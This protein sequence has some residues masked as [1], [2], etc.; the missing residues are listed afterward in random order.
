MVGGDDPGEE[1]PAEG[2]ARGD[3]PETSGDEQRE[4]ARGMPDPGPKP[5]GSFIWKFDSMAVNGI[6]GP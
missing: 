6:S 5:G 4:P 3:G 2:Q 1:E